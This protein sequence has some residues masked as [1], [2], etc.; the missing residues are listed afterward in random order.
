MRLCCSRDLSTKVSCS[1]LLSLPCL[2]KR[3]AALAYLNIE[4][5]NIPLIPSMLGHD[6]KMITEKSG[7][8]NW[9]RKFATESLRLGWEVRVTWSHPTRVGKTWNQKKEMKGTRRNGHKIWGKNSEFSDRWW[10]PLTAPIGKTCF[11]GSYNGTFLIIGNFR[12]P[13]CPGSVT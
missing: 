6:T 7:Q 5:S 13:A 10:R 4:P 3:A 2:C 11:L 9:R 1:R 8:F 12:W